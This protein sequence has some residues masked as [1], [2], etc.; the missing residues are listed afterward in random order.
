LSSVDGGTTVSPA[1]RASAGA[2]L[3]MIEAVAYSD[4]QM[5]RIKQF[6]GIFGGSINQI[7]SA[8]MAACTCGN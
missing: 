2:A 5:S 7:R 8:H 3:R 1:L 4:L 6:Q